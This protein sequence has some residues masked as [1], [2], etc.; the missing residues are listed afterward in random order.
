MIVGMELMFT[1]LFLLRLASFSYGILI[2]LIL[3]TL[4]FFTVRRIMM[5]GMASLI[6]LVAKYF[7]YWKIFEMGV[8]HLLINYIILG[9]TTGIYI[10]LPA[11]YLINRFVNRS[12]RNVE[13]RTE[14]R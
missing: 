12:Q 13:N 11:L 3:Y 14:K 1:P 7:I 10:S 8:K 4:M 9:F 6:V 2:V 5:G